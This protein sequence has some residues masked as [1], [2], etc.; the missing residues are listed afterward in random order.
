VLILLDPYIIGF[1][2]SFTLIFSYP[3][4]EFLHEQKDFECSITKYQKSYNIFVTSQKS[5]QPDPVGS[6]YC[7]L[8]WVWIRTYN[9]R[10]HNTACLVILEGVLTQ[11][12]CYLMENSPEPD[13]ESYFFSG[14]KVSLSAQQ[15]KLIERDGR[16]HNFR[17]GPNMIFTC[18]NCLQA[19]VAV[20]FGAL[21]ENLVRDTK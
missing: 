10:I 8:S 15:I 17:S 6:V 21:P 4:K 7:W 19:N 14:V 13:F 9:I 12:K 5:L 2:G 11:A 1:P 18:Y 20:V 16:S 3:L